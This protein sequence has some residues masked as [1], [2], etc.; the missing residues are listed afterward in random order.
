MALAQPEQL[1]SLDFSGDRLHSAIN[2][3]CLSR[4]HQNPQVGIALPAAV[5]SSTMHGSTFL[6]SRLW[7]VPRLSFRP[8]DITRTLQLCPMATFQFKTLEHFAFIFSLGW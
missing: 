1:V 3:P 6:S 8:S 4:A 2:D 7:F 5:H